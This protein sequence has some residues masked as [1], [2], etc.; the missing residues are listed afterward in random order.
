LRNTRLGRAIGL[1]G[2]QFGTRFNLKTS[3]EAGFHGKGLGVAAETSASGFDP[4]QGVFGAK[5]STF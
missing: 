1:D 5:I 3:D 2:G 4:R